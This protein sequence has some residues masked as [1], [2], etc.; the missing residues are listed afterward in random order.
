MIPRIEVKEAG[1]DTHPGRVTESPP[2]LRLAGES[3]LT[4]WQVR[5]CP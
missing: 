1:K 3:A 4:N 2:S 5:D